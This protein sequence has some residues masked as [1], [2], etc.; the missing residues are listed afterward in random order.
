MPSERPD[1]TPEAETQA[2][3][4]APNQA[5]GNPTPTWSAASDSNDQEVPF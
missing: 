4:P 1:C 5:P 2:S 3:S